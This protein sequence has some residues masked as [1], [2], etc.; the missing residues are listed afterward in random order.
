VKNVKTPR[1]GLNYYTTMARSWASHV[2]VIVGGLSDHVALEFMGFDGATAVPADV[3]SHTERAQDV[4]D[5]TWHLVA[6][7]SWSLSKHCCPPYSCAP[8][9][10]ANEALRTTTAEAMRSEWGWLLRLEQMA[11]TV[12]DAKQLVRDIHWASSVPIRLLHAFFE[13]EMW[14]PGS[15]AGQRWLRALLQHLPDNK[16][17]EDAHSTIRKE[18]RANAN[19]KMTG[20]HIQDCVIASSVLEKRDIPHRSALTELSFK[21]HY[22][23]A[24]R[25]SMKGHATAR[26]H[27]L[28][29]PWTALM[30][31]K[32]WSSPTPEA[33]LRAT[34][35]WRWLG[36]YFCRV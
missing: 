21:A 30:G 35:G 4:L 6:H 11:L 16:I 36:A 14:R 28:P 33:A 15:R 12:P 2:Q 34:A 24:S 19:T 23:S 18:C 20:L 17:V 5:L 25:K 10:S 27:E 22:A 8:V 13:R 7:R 31:R 29:Q 32:T 26:K 3:A 1:Q 9:C